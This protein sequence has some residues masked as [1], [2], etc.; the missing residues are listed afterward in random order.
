MKHRAAKY[1]SAV[2]SLPQNTTTTITNPPTVLWKSTRITEPEIQSPDYSFFFLR[3]SRLHG[4]KLTV[5]PASVDGTRSSHLLS[6]VAGA[7]LT[8]PLTNLSIPSRRS[9]KHRLK[10]PARTIAFS[11]LCP[12][13][14][15]PFPLPVDPFHASFFNQPIRY[16]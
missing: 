4:Y 6:A 12:H 11:A 15:S 3:K 5:A 10:A 8:N 13:P 2:Q 1:S 14:S 16:F 7:P 9:T